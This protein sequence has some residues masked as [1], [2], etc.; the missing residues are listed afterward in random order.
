MKY[1]LGI[2]VGKYYHQ[3]ILAGS[4]GKPMTNSLRFSNSFSGYQQLNAYLEKQLLVSEFSKVHAGMEATGPYWLSLYEQLKKLGIHTTVLNPLQV[5]S[6]RNE[7]IRGSKT[8]SIDCLLIVKILRFGDYKAS[9]LPDG[10][11]LALRQLTRLRADLVKVTSGLKMKLLAIFEQ[12]FP[13][14]PKLF[15]DMFGP[16]AQV[17]LSEAIDPESIAL[18]PTEKL[19]AILKKSSHGWFGEKKAIEIKQAARDS[20]GVTIGLDAFTLSA[21]ILLTQINH[22][23]SQ[24]ESLNDEITKRLNN[25]NQSLTSIPGVGETTAAAIISEIGNFDRFKDDKNGAEKLVALAGIDPKLKSSG[26]NKGKAIMSK[27]GSPYL[28]NAVRHASFIAATVKKDPM[29]A[30]IYQK[31]IK[32]G[33]HF[34]VAL[35]HVENKLLHVVFSL[36]KSRKQYEPYAVKAEKF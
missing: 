6:Y 33:K 22:L 1:Y 18:I 21:Q 12:I 10:D 5:K 25:Y 36:L 26:E 19:T 4:E 2:D 14:Y 8:D 3:A 23:D 30:G 28:R 17:V 35:S 9:D 27:R 16:G 24:V 32:E 15:T 13:E 31:K 11:L 34:E 7:D 29:F 20:I